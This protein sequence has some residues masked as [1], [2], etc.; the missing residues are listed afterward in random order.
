MAGS[1]RPIE[2]SLASGVIE[3]L[4]ACVAIPVFRIGKKRCHVLA[5][6]TPQS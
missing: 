6:I 2:T 1:V 4:L 3:L 5:A